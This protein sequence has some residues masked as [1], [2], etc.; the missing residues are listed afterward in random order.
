MSETRHT[1]EPWITQHDGEEWGIFRAGSCHFVTTVTG[2]VGTE[3]NAHRIVACVNALAGVDDPEAELVYLRKMRD[4]TREQAAEL[5]EQDR[6]LARLR[7]VEQ[8]A[9]AYI[10]A[11]PDVSDT[12]ALYDALERAVGR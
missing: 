7:R 11:D 12:L 8:A 9:R 4:L 3:E 1:P 10:N 6:E 5:S 2:V